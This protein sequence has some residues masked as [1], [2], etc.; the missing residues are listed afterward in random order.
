MHT[1]KI[2]LAC[3][4]L[5]TL[6]I[7]CG[8][9]TSS[10]TEVQRSSTPQSSASQP[11]DAIPEVLA[12]IGDEKI[13]LTDLR[14]RIGD[15]LDQMENQYRR[16]R[17][18]AIETALT[19]ALQERVIQAEATKQGKTVDQLLAAEAGGSLEPSEVEISAW[20]QDNQAKT[21]GRSLD[22]IRTQIAEY[23]R[24]E[25]SKEATEKLQQ[26]L[27]QER[28]VTVLLEPYR[29]QFNNAGAPAIGPE[30]ARLTLVEFSDFEC[31]YCGR[32]FPTVKRLE[33]EFG[34]ELRILYRQYPITN[35]H[36]SAFKA[37]EASLCAHEQG[38]F[39][40]MHDLLF[41]EQQKISVRDLKE[42]AGR[43]GL[44]QSK[45]DGC[46]DTGRYI[47]QVQ[48]DLKEGKRVGV[49]GTPA[50]FLNGVSIDGGAVPYETIVKAIEKEKARGQP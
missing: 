11:A 40:E 19:A 14:G 5:A 43:L 21:G 44:N 30:D 47:E 32:F 8:G 29:L 49:T 27:N 13:T 45:F 28:K 33:A 26:R 9:G 6:L 16:A 10:A 2:E 31:P 25:R 20:Y 23:L 34:K 17:Q 22:Q 50:L 35:I 42:K 15:D 12:T 4:G 39:W 37:A 48:E 38:K 18:R 3:L 36:P 24:K 46:L 41:Q 1:S 7:G